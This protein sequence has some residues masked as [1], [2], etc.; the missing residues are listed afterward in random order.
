[1]KNAMNKQTYRIAKFQGETLIGYMEYCKGYSTQAVG[2][3]GQI[4]ACESSAVNRATIYDRDVDRR[5]AQ[6]QS[7]IAAGRAHPNRTWCLN[8]SWRNPNGVKNAAFVEMLERSL[9][10]L[11]NVSFVVQTC[12]TLSF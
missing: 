12:A 5:I 6:L 10:Q 11:E 4:F 8:A 3:I 2:P 9:A 1:M 7:E